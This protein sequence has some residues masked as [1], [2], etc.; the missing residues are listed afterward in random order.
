MVQT[1]KEQPTAIQMIAKTAVPMNEQ[2]CKINYNQNVTKFADIGQSTL[3][4]K[5]TQFKSWV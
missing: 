3:A 1:V 5:A 2:L 4:G